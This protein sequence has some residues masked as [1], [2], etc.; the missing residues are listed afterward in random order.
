M[1]QVFT[2]VYFVNYW[3][4]DFNRCC[5]SEQQPLNT[6][7]SENFSIERMQNF[8][9]TCSQRSIHDSK[10]KCIQTKSKI[11][12]LGR[13]PLHTRMN[14]MYMM[15]L[16]ELFVYSHCKYVILCYQFFYEF[17]LL[18]G[19]DIQFVPINL[20]VHRLVR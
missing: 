13:S 16:K 17:G 7:H 20:S 9:L 5:S 6:V 14:I 10:N 3:Y 11:L 15:A 4:L 18:L 12:L 8:R 2:I 19:S 1:F